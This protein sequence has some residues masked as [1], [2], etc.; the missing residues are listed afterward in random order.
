[1]EMT[2][3]ENLQRADLN[4]MEQAR[5]FERLGREFKLTQEQMAQRTG[6]DRASVSNF[7][8]LLRLPMEVQEKVEGGSIELRSRTRSSAA[9]KPGNY[10][11]GRAEGRGTLDVRPTD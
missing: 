2:I 9:R 10:S 11:E 5:A 1:M 4:P 6:K 8:R 7:L 3:V